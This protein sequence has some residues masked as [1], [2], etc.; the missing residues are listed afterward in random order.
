MS[1]V[2]RDRIDPRFRARRIEVR[3][4]AGRRRLNRL[5]ILGIGVAVVAL[6]GVAAA[7]PLLDVGTVEVT[8]MYRTPPEDVIEAG[9]I[10]EGDPL[11]LVDPGAAADRVEALPWVREAH[12][13]REWS[14]TIRYE[15]QERTPLVAVPTND[16][17]WMA[18]DADGRL[19]ATLDS[20]PTDLALLVGV[21]ATGPPGEQLDPA[22]RPALLVAEAVATA[23][24]GG[25]V[26]AGPD[27]TVDL[28]LAAGGT[29]SFGRVDDPDEVRHQA[30]ALTTVL[31]AV[32][33]QCVARLDLR[34]AEAPVLTR[35]PACR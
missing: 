2:T 29:V 22:A 28:R 13:R 21:E 10:D 14:G 5:A 17:G 35:S 20:A 8:G 11:L 31:G 9:G 15:I 26:A 16:G 4:D 19:V 34:A 25:T 23:A 24:P 1:V 27:A 32:G 7:S 3:R 18:A 33:P 6:A 30:V 12:V